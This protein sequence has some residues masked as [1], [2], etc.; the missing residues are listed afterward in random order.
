MTMPPDDTPSVRRRHKTLQE[1]AE[2]FGIFLIERLQLTAED[3]ATLGDELVDLVH[4]HYSGQSLYFPKDRGYVRLEHDTY[5]WHHLRRGNASEIAAHLGVSYVY[6][7][8]RYRVML[9]ESRRR[10]QPQLPGMDPPETDG[11]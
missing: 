11:A 1:M 7:Y 6:V 10:T 8:Q 9:A 5:I 3:A 4:R 2:L